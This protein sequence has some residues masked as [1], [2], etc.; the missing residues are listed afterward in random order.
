M[1]GPIC[2]NCGAQGHNLMR[3]T[4][5]TEPLRPGFHSGGSGGGG[6]GGDDEDEHYTL[7]RSERRDL[8]ATTVSFFDAS[9]ATVRSLN[10][11]TLVIQE[12]LPVASVLTLVV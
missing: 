2:S 11:S 1:Y 9:S 4:E 6:H 3:C 7:P 8:L 5:L 12:A 10:S